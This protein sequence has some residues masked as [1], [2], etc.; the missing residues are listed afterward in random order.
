MF[1]CGYK[2]PRIAINDYRNAIDNMR[3]I[4]VIFHCVKC[5]DPI[6]TFWDED[7]DLEGYYIGVKAERSEY[8]NKWVTLEAKCG[9]CL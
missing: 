1:D 4:K 7:G 5:G 2:L 6:T 3:K 9:M 8:L